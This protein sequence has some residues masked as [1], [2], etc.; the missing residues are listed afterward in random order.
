MNGTGAASQSQAA[1]DPATIRTDFYQTPTTLVASLFL[2]QIDPQSSAV[3]FTD[4]HTIDLDLK[5]KDG[6]IYSSPIRLWGN[7]DPERSKYKILGTK[8]EFELAKGV[9]SAGASWPALR[10]GEK[11]SGEIIQ[12]G[13][14]GRV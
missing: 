11:G 2:K 7:I 12:S 13:R 4:S 8:L 3:K 5:T 6:R 9:D 1:I 10:E 14:A